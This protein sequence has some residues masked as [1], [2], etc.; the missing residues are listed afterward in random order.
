MLF[1]GS[2]FVGVFRFLF[3]FRVAVF[4]FN[5]LFVVVNVSLGLRVVGLFLFFIF[6]L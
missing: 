2:L 4:F 5:V 1:R 3:G 6:W